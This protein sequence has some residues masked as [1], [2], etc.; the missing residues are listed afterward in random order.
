MGGDAELELVDRLDELPRVAELL[1]SGERSLSTVLSI[2]RR[3]TPDNETVL[4]ER[5]VSGEE[6][7]WGSVLAWEP[8]DRLVFSYLGNPG[9]GSLHAISVPHSAFAS[10]QS[11][12]SDAPQPQSHTPSA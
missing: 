2:A 6:S 4:V 5:S 3:A 11:M 12:S 10:A 8:P 7:V 1:A 9:V